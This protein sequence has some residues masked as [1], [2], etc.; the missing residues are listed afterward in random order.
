MKVR[1]EFRNGHTKKVSNTR[2]SRQRYWPIFS[3][4]SLR[5]MT[6]HSSSVAKRL[7][8]G[9]AGHR[10]QAAWLHPT[11]VCT[12]GPLKRELQGKLNLPRRPRGGQAL[13]L[14]CPESGCV[15]SILRAAIGEQEIG[16]VREVEKLRSKLQ[17]RF[18]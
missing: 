15:V 10:P 3:T 8:S 17:I 6:S 13:V 11:K 18:L 1:Q 7:P 16:V 9:D 4:K 2:G 14:R 12:A 5:N